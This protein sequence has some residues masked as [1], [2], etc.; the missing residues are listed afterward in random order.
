MAFDDRDA[1]VMQQTLQVESV[2]R[3]EFVRDR[4]L[5]G[6]QLKILVTGQ[7]KVGGDVVRRI[8]KTVPQSVIDASWPGPQ[9]TLKAWLL[10]IIDA[11]V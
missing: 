11:A 3:I 8:T 10:A 7:A 4:S 5:P 2:E 6:V 1:Q 9:R